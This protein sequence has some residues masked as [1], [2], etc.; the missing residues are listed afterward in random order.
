MIYRDYMKRAVDVVLASLALLVAG[1]VILLAAALIRLTSPGPAFFLQQRVGL[2]GCSFTIFK[3]RT[4]HVN[5]ARVLSQTR[6][7]DPDVFA[8]GRVLRRLKI[9]ELPQILNVLKGDMSLIGPR[10]C[11]RQTYELMEEWA[12]ERSL[13]RP[14]LTGLAQVSGGVM[15]TWEQRS[16]LD[17]KYVRECSALLDLRI[18]LKTVAV[19][20]LGEEKF[21]QAVRG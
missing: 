19:V 9:D 8:V 1:P 6:G 13:L 4:M 16:C 5:E 14:G 10:P 3:L 15:L 2:R 18:V 11:M 17:V 12:K 20:L 21:V 7:D